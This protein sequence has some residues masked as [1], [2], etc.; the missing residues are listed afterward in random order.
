MNLPLLP[1]AEGLRVEVRLVP[2]ARRTQIS[3]LVEG[4]DGRVALKVSVTAQ[5]EAGKANA[6]LIEFLADTWRLPKSAIALVAGHAARRKSVL[7]RG[8]GKAL[9]ARIA[10][11]LPA[12]ADRAPVAE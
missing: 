10:P 8:D 7:I 3:G 4:A 11:M 12:A 1:V 5:P 6:A 9:L 2:G